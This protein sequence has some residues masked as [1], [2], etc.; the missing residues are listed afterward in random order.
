M[1]T[2]ICGLF[3]TRIVCIS[4]Q[5]LE[6]QS[7]TVVD[8]VA[9]PKPR[10]QRLRNVT[11]LEIPVSIASERRALAKTRISRQLYKL[12]EAYMER[13]LPG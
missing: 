10:F 5:L 13:W 12:V 8:E 3:A 9:V 1:E 7:R 2:G 6:S 4:P 11:G